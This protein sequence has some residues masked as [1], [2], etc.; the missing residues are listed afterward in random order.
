MALLTDTVQ[1]KIEP[2]N[3]IEGNVTTL[4]IMKTRLADNTQPE[5]EFLEINP[6]P[7]S[8][9]GGISETL[10]R[11]YK[12]KA[13]FGELKEQYNVLKEECRHTHQDLQT[14]LKQPSFTETAERLRQEME[15]SLRLK[16]EAEKHIKRPERLIVL[17]A[18]EKPAHEE[19]PEET[20]PP[21]PLEPKTPCQ[22]AESIY[23]KVLESLK[24][25]SVEEEDIV[26][27]VMKAGIHPD[28]VL[29]VTKE[30][31]ELMK[32]RG[33]ISTPRGTLK[34]LLGGGKKKE[35]KEKKP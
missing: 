27:A 9:L 14:I 19:K 13:L 16:E 17:E 33:A 7:F 25:K 18:D 32:E 26:A 22:Q 4:K 21:Q 3:I 28:D 15:E 30:I 5:D 23:D 12:A 11:H 29:K 34:R 20:A 24:G 6:T 1:I 2:Y 8:E 35:K 10:K 31:I